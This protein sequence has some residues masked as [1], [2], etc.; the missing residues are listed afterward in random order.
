MTVIFRREWT[1]FFRRAR[2]YLFLGGFLFCLG[3][4]AS[5]FHFSYGYGN[6][7]YV[8][9]YLTVCLALLLP[10]VTVPLFDSEH[11]DGACRLLGSLGFS[12]MQILLGKFSFAVSLLGG[13]TALLLFVPPFLGMFGEV[14]YPSAFGAIFGWAAIGFAILSLDVF[15]SLMIRN[16]RWAWVVTYGVTLL[17]WALS[18]V[19]TAIA[20]PIGEVLSETFLLGSYTPFIFGMFDLGSVLYALAVGA[21]FFCLA[22]LMIRKRQGFGTTERKG[23]LLGITALSLAIA[24]GLSVGLSLIPSRLS[25]LDVTGHEFYSLNEETAPFIASLNSPATVYLLTTGNG[26]RSL[27]YYLERFCEA[28]DQLT[29]RA[30][31]PK[32]SAERLTSMGASTESATDSV[33]I[34]GAKRSVL[35]SYEDLFYYKTD[36]TT[37]NSMGLSE[38]TLSEYYYYVSLFGQ[39]EQYAEYLM[40]LTESSKMYFR[41]EAALSAALEYVCAAILPTH[42]VLTGHGEQTLSGTVFSELLATYG[43]G[44]QLLDLT[45][46][47]AIPEDAASLL[48]V[49]PTSDYTEG[50]IEMLRAYLARGGVLSVVTGQTQLTMTN[51][52]ALLSE[53]GLSAESGLV[54]VEKTILDEEETEEPKKEIVSSVDVSVNLDHDSMAAAT[55]EQD[56]LPVITGGNAISFSE[57]AGSSL[58]LTPILTTSEQ[59]MIGDDPDTRGEKILAAAAETAEGAKL[60]WFTGAESFC[61]S[62]DVITEELSGIYNAYC[63]YLVR[64]W[65]DLTYESKAPAAD[66]KQYDTSYLQMSDTSSMLWI[67]I[68][69]VLIPTSVIGTGLWVRSRRK[70]A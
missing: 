49:S 50:E 68:T 4:F 47:S 67:L 12:P 42:Y 31:S 61:L 41:G 44:Y 1:S 2:G 56:F 25:R 70:K 18:L 28:N 65:S 27:E 8:L 11:R 57:K 22:S 40:A 34:E 24:L 69:T 20:L 35:L 38:M 19:G 36:H 43:Q 7:E 48:L 16:R 9:S 33:L 6:F 55:I 3:L 13:L 10:I 39:D 52:M 29:F 51:L 17:L 23:R 53:Y 14:A 60:V 64:G 21:I 15:L 62:R 30:M 26:D 66:A 46:V 59:A 45:A 54:C 5:I 63:L 58:L 32:E 37:L